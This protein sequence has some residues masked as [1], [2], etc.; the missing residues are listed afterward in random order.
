MGLCLVAAVAVSAVAVASASAAPEYFK[1][2]KVI[3]TVVKYTNLGPGPSKL[4]GGVVIECQKDKGKGQIE[5]PDKTAKLKVEY[6]E[7]VGEVGGKPVVCQKTA[8]KPGVILTNA[9]KG[10]LVKASEKPAGAEIVA[11]KLEPEVLGKP[12]AKFKCGT[13]TVEVNGG[14]IVRPEPIGGGDSLK[15]TSTN[16]LQGTE[17]EPGCTTQQL[18]YV[19]GAKPCVH[20]FTAAGNSENV[21]FDEVTFKAA[22]EIHP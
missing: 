13:L 3:T 19:N 16:S 11:N 1:A 14:I 20:L 5:A 18:L 12:F 4:L 6:K 8:T 10:H 15:G 22:V 2:G 21:S 17:P 9:L 7:C